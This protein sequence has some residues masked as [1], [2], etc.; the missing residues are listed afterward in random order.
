MRAFQRLLVL[1]QPD[2]SMDTVIGEIL[3]VKLFSEFKFSPAESSA[4]ARFAN[5]LF[6][7]CKEE[8]KMTPPSKNEQVITAMSVFIRM[9]DKV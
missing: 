9:Y 8:A 1:L 5:A 2:I 7:S 3:G 6:C 4:N